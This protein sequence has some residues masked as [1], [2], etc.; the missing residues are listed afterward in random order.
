M[1]KRARAY[2]ERDRDDRDVAQAIMRALPRGCTRAIARVGGIA[3][4][5]AVERD[6]ADGAAGDARSW[7]MGRGHSGD[8]RLL[9][10]SRKAG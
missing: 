7:S 2:P 10:R 4:V 6:R 9:V 3:R 1:R 5:L 8:K